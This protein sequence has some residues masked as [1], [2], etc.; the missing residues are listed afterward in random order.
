MHSRIRVGGRQAKSRRIEL[1]MY[2]IPQA[3]NSAVNEA[4]K[5]APAPLHTSSR[6]PC[7]CLPS[8]LLMYCI[9]GIWRERRYNK[10]PRW[11]VNLRHLDVL[12]FCLASAV[13]VFCYKNDPKSIRPSFYFLMK[14]LWA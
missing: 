8:C 11:L 14:W 7:S 3:L 13:T 4:I 6:R 10:L 2:C 1:A 12:F 5:Y 9:W